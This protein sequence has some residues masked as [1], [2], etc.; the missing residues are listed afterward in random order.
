MTL[1]LGTVVQARMGSTRLPGKVLLDIGGRPMLQHVLGRAALARRVPLVILATT[2]LPMDDPV[3]ALGDR[4][5]VPVVRGPEEDVLERYHLA[6]QR[7]S[8]DVVVR[9]TSDCPFL[10]A[11]LIDRAVELLLEDP[12]LAYV[13][14]TLER[15]YPRGFD[16]EAIR[17]SALA[18]AA[19]EARTAWERE[20]VTPFVWR[21]PDRFRIAQIC[22]EEDLSSWRLTVD[23]AEDLALIRAVY[24][25]LADHAGPHFGLEEVVQLLE[26]EPALLELNAGVQQKVLPAE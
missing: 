4:L 23:Q 19:A 18:V 5:G 22:H 15:T 10:D 14:N 12:T 21:R 20:H 9:V 8:L 26:R 11:R 24:A 13:S 17:T 2:A 7:H 16:V 3:A 25:R 1:R 6:A